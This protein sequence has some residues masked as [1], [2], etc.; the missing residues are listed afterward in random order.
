MGRCRQKAEPRQQS[1]MFS[2]R[3][4]RRGGSTASTCR[5]RRCTHFR[6]ASRC[7]ARPLA[8]RWPDRRP[9]ARSSTR[10]S[11]EPLRW[12]GELA[13][14][15]GLSAHGISDLERRARRLRHRDTIARLSQALE[16]D[17]A[18]PITRDLRDRWLV[19]LRGKVTNQDAE[20]WGPRAGIALARSAGLD[21]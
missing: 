20:R 5:S 3:R 19:P 10:W 13:E 9:L 1:P 12:Q 21:V 8:A 2:G 14:Q 18:F 15:A 17:D 6:A 16:L 7:N 4:V 11:V